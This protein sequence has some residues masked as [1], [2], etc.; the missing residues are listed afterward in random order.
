MI[1]GLFKKHCA[2]CKQGIGK[3][4]AIKKFG[5]YLCSEE[6]SEEYRKNL[7]EKESKTATRGE[8]CC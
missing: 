6:H 4:K 8:G 5:K 1:L 7:A 2:V 3:E